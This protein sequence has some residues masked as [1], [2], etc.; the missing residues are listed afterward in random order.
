M[1]EVLRMYIE[2]TPAL[3]D[4]IRILDPA[5]LGDSAKTFHSIKGASLNIGAKKVGEMA[6]TLEKAA[7]EG[8]SEA[9]VSSCQEFIETVEGLIWQMTAYL[10]DIAPSG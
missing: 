9:V 6:A 5:N 7:K 10:N 2:T 8:D 4:R 1:A 3:L